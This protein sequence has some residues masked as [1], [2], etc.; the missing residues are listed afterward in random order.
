MTNYRARGV[1]AEVLPAFAPQGTSTS[2]EDLVRAYCAAW[3]IDVLLRTLARF[4]AEFAGVRDTARDAVA[5]H[6]DLAKRLNGDNELSPD[7]VEKFEKGH[8][9]AATSNIQMANLALFAIANREWRGIAQP[10]SLLRLLGSFNYCTQRKPG[11][12]SY[13]VDPESVEAGFAVATSHVDRHLNVVSRY[14][15]FFEWARNNRT[16]IDV[17]QLFTEQANLDYEQYARCVTALDEYY[18]HRK[19]LAVGM[20]SLHPTQITEEGKPLHQW[21]ASR[22][23][24]EEEVDAFLS[25][26]SFITLRDRGYFQT[27]STPF[28][29]YRGAYYLLNPRALDNALGLGIFYVA[30]D[31]LTRGRGD[32]RDRARAAQDYFAFAGRFFEPYAGDLLR[33]IADRSGSLWH[34]EVRDAEGDM[35]TDFFV[36]EG[37][38]AIFFEVRFG[39]VAKPVIE[40]L[41]A[42]KIEEAFEQIIYSKAEQLDRNVKRFAEGLLPIC[43]T[44]PGTIRKVYP[45]VCLP[46]PFPRSPAIQNKIDAELRSRGWLPP[47]VNGVEVAPLEII[48]AESLEGLAGLPNQVRFSDLID[49][50]VSTTARFTFFKNFL[51]EVKGLAL[52]MDPEREAEI[53][54]SVAIM[55]AE[56]KAWIA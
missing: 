24:T 35:S 22:S 13:Y 9:T 30:L 42:A 54:A 48:E 41:S 25:D 39:R 36:I 32:G 15:A 5:Y 47:T 37:D 10:V 4:S 31:A 16:A 50:K 21:L 55:T 17:P 12:D 45:V 18:I 8:L 51:T 27:L 43:G 49:E 3:D 44:G 34:G 29:Q 20:P 40:N 53:A 33:K 23:L 14:W 19:M 2:A 1:E 46:S 28:V 56:T 52:R 11:T 6:L 26:D 7:L 38:K